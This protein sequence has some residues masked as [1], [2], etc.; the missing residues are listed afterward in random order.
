MQL[1]LKSFFGL[2]VGS[3]GVVYGD[4]GTSPLYAMREAVLA[5][6]RHGIENQEA[7]LGVLSLI[8]WVLLLIVTLKYILILLRADNKGEGGT[9]ALMA[10]GQSV[11]KRSA[12]LIFM[13]GVLGVTFFY[14]DS[15]LTPAISVLSAVEGLKLVSP[16]FSR[17]IVPLAV[18][19]LIALFAAQSRG[20][21]KVAMFF[22][23]IMVLWFI[24]I[25]LG[26][27]IHLSDNISILK[28]I[29]PLH[30][31][32]FVT[33]A[34]VTGLTVIGLVFLA[35]T[36][37][38]GLYADLGHFG[39]KP[40]QIAWLCFV[41][42]S[43][44]LN[45]FGQGALLLSSPEAIQNPFYKLYPEWAL[46]PM[47]VLATLATVIA[48]QSVITGAFSITRQAI[49]LGLLP[50]MAIQHT[51]ET[52]AGQI[53]LPRLNW[54]LLFLVLIVVITFRSSS[55]L[56][57][58]YGV[59]VSASMVIDSYMAFFVIWK[60]WKLPVWQALG[61]MVPLIFIEHSFFMS[62]IIKVYDGGWIPLTIASIVAMIM[63]TWIRGYKL[64]MKQA[65][66]DK[67]DLNWLSQ[68]LESKT[69]TRING[70][71]VFLSS[72]VNA[73]PT[74]LMHNLKHN[75]VLHERNI[76]M[77]IHT[78][79]TP[80][81]PRAERLEIDRS[82]Q[83]FTKVEVRYGFMETPSIPK[84]IDN[85]RRKDLNIDLGS[86]SFFLSRRSLQKSSNSELPSW[87]QRLFILLAKTSEDASLYFQIPTDRAVE[88]GAQ[89]TI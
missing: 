71:A 35:V 60:Y 38:E 68:R 70:T 36:G 48:C 46:I 58:A 85:C 23:P 18:A 8:F 76:I 51:S 49:Q 45:Y 25:A 33:T 13:L 64:L 47:L 15:V 5:A 28:A 88:I 67:V 50:R 54:L 12:P 27:A 31:L 63:W 19:I 29:N 82:N 6:N 84:I 16:E 75:H 56:A 55:H 83:M 10:L 4:I 79:D 44:I 87:Q 86:T 40:I 89:V 24:S 26:G 7:I 34:G 21:S 14:G 62:N 37:A 72:D 2:T 53:Y 52:V 74:S 1:N 17:F 42:P 59:S 9:F 77:A 39:R 61:I 20:T 3:V 32:M 73:A 41:F 66:K 81:I 80:R 30:G 43:L 57:A 11:A 69:T 65:H 22:G 78:I